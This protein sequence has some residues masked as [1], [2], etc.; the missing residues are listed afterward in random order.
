M[1]KDSVLELKNITKS[2]PGVPRALD[3]VSVS[4]A[5][6]K[7]HAL[8]G[9]NGAGKSTLIK[10]LS[11]AHMPNSGE[12]YLNGKLI[13]NMTPHMAL[14]LGIGVIYQEFNLVPALSV[15]ENV[16]LGDMPGNMVTID[17]AEV[18]RK[19]AEIF[20]EI[21]VDIDPRA[22][23]QDLTIAY[24]QLVEIA[25]A[26]SRKVQILI[27][28]EPTAALTASEAES[29]FRI[30]DRL[31]VRGVTIIYVSHRFSE[32]FRIADSIT[33][34]RD[35]RVV[36]VT[37]AKDIDRN[38]LIRAMVGRDVSDAYP[39]RDFPVGDVV[40]ELKGVGGGIVENV[41]F[42]V[43][44]GEIVGLGG[45]VGAGRTEVMRMVFAADKRDTGHILLDGD[46]IAPT[47]PKHA[48]AL[49]IGMLP[50]DRKHQGLFLELPIKWNITMAILRKLSV[51]TVLNKAKENTLVS[52]LIKRMGVKTPTPMQLPRNLSGGNQQKVGVCKWLAAG[53]RVMI[54]DEPTRGVDVGARREIYTQM[55]DLC[56]QGI[57]IVMIS[58][59]M[60]ELLGMSDRIVV[61]SEGEQTRILE[62]D[63]FSQE[64]VLFHASTAK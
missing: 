24:K 62:K 7:V 21:E 27:L 60:E 15:A 20:K 18:E 47:S 48:V 54:F 51:A 12:I 31:K 64:A 41:N 44:K 14:K 56:R 38:G 8:M 50:E 34:M 22:L 55:N 29:L 53:S 6:G 57:A 63:E 9:E 2:F 30:I 52:D 32:I 23:V 17:R 10:T 4:F 16:F 25:K 49:G 45:L 40:L 1:D 46:E 28:D 42:A 58:S 59:D 39:R 5:R 35:G 43:R 26:L 3:G 13:E 61:M 37:D 36:Q 11:A 19:T 33:V